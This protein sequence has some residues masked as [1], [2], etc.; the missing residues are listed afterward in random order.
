[1]EWKQEVEKI[2]KG[3]LMEALGME[4]LELEK[5]RV[6]GKMPVDERTVQP[7]KI[8]HGGASAAFAETL[9]SLGSYVVLKDTDNY[10]VGLELNANH[11]RPASS[12]FVYGEA[13]LIHGGRTTHIWEI[14][15]TNEE[16]K[17]VCASRLTMIVKQKQ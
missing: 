7:F 6:V 12:G 1:M 9:G 2:A 4:I 17:L 5:G 8:L 16:K 13:I 10:A 3:T 14:K 15:I 11:I